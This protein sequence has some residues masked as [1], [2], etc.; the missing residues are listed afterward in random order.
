MSKPLENVTDIGGALADDD[1]FYTVQDSSG[2]GRKSALSRLWTYIQSKGRERLTA[3]RTYYVNASTGSDSNDGLTSGT[4]FATIAKAYSVIV[5]TLDLAGYTVTIQL[6]DGTY[7]AGLTINVPWTGGG[8]V[9]LQGNSSTPSN[10]VISLANGFPVIFNVPLPGGLLIKDVKLTTGTSGDCIR[11][12]GAGKCQFTNVE[13][14]AAAWWHI[15]V[16]APGC[17][18]EALGNYAISGSPGFSHIGLI[19]N[20]HFLSAG[21]TITITNTPAWGIAFLEASGA[22]SAQMHGMT[23]TGAAT[24]ARFNVKENAA[25][26]IAGAGATYFPGNSAGVFG[27]KTFTDSNSDTVVVEQGV[28]A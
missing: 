2:N 17:K 26:Y 18:M 27:T 7:T 21:R 14:G 10:V 15:Y 28:V 23:F 16:N 20:T 9:T 12:N 22:A 4:A 5:S 3:N 6:A 19:A 25:I 13:F 24:G 1:L 11:G 8:S